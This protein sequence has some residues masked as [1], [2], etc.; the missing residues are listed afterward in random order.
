MSRT[1]DYICWISG[2]TT[3]L[4]DI[5]YGCI[6]KKETRIFGLGLINQFD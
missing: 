2:E 1:L 6:Y 3:H 5:N 4:D